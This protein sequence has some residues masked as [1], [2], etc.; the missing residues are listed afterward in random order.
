MLQSLS[1]LPFEIY[2]NI[3]QDDDALFFKI[4]FLCKKLNERFN[5]LTKYYGFN[6]L[7]DVNELYNK[8]IKNFNFANIR[9]QNSISC[10]DGFL[11]YCRTVN[12]L[13][14]HHDIYTYDLSTFI[15][16]KILK[17]DCCVSSEEKTIITLPLNIEELIIN[18]YNFY[19][20]KYSLTFKNASNVK[21]LT[22]LHINCNIDW[23][24]IPPK[25]ITHLSIMYITWF[26]IN[27]NLNF[28]NLTHLKIKRMLTE[29][30]KLIPK[31]VRCLTISYLDIK[32]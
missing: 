9:V 31:S 18:R 30:L 23:N 8:N 7:I 20:D 12:Q 27:Y 26:D 10:L 24:N 17:F 5:E 4:K 2:L 28:S 14:I 22:L 13:I 21:K 6:T 29:N 19:E 25:N 11:S 3:I 15:N 16:L 1:I 32:K